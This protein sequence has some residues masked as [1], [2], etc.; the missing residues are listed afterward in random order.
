MLNGS[1][2]IGKLSLRRHSLNKPRLL[3]QVAEIEASIATIDVNKVP[4]NGSKKWL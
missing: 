1:S 2:N 3:L 4:N